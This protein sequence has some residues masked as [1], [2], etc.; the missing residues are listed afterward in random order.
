M[1]RALALIV[2]ISALGV[3]AKLAFKEDRAPAS[4]PVEEGDG[5]GPSPDVSDA[6]RLAAK[7]PEDRDLI[8]RVVERYRRT[9]TEV[10]ASEGLRGLKLLDRLDLEA[11]FLFERHP[12]EFHQLASVVGDEAAAELLTHWAGYFG[13]KRADD[14]DR[15]VLIAEITRL[16]PSRRRIAG[17]YPHALPLILAEPEGVCDLIR[18]L[19]DD[20]KALND[21]LAM[22]DLVSLADGSQS[23]RAALE[24]LEN[25]R[26]LA[27]ESF[28]GFGPEG[29]RDGDPLWS[30]PR[31]RRPGHAAR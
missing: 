28:R 6:E 17:R 2:L 25:R 30:G 5:G 10:E 8:A 9:A 1:K 21:A 7:Y 13:L 27:L 22:L 23:L 26:G 16:A 14:V 31:R 19:E 29:V 24:T 15:E 11:I 18:R 4:R 3:L 12:D 20:P